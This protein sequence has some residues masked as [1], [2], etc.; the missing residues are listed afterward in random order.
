MPG[1]PR[2]TLPQ[3]DTSCC[4]SSSFSA[5]SSERAVCFRKLGKTHI[6]NIHGHRSVPVPPKKISQGLTDEQES[7]TCRSRPCTAPVSALARELES[8]LCHAGLFY[9]SSFHS[10]KTSANAFWLIYCLYRLI[11][12]PEAFA[13]M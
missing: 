3:G 12:H 1:G 4:I 5:C 9:F 7:L 11:G 2:G 6:L 8:S 10:F 13:Y